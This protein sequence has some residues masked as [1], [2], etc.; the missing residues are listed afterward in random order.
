MTL[1][2]KVVALAAKM[3]CTVHIDA[4]SI[5]T[6]SVR[7]EAPQGK[8]FNGLDLHELYGDVDA[9]RQKDRKGETWADTDVWKP[10]LEDLERGPLEDCEVEDCEWCGR[11]CCE[12]SCPSDNCEDPAHR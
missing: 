12:P 5:D 1:R 7:I 2:Q 10:L 6:L 3:G 9:P 8:V 4:D 11:A